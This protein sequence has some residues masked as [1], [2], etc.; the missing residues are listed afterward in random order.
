MVWDEADVCAC[1]CV[2]VRA[3]VSVCEWDDVDVDVHSR[4]RLWRRISSVLLSDWSRPTDCSAPA[5]LYKA[6]SS[7]SASPTHPD[8]ISH[9]IST[10]TH[11]H[12]SLNCT[13][14]EYH[15]TNWIVLKMKVNVPKTTPTVSRHKETL[16]QQQP[17]RFSVHKTH[18]LQGVKNKSTS[19]YTKHNQSNENMQRFEDIKV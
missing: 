4:K 14:T 16:P 17:K 3:C 1:V 12:Y 7:T 6:D 2:C 13:F 18:H 10:T 5:C 15:Q 19:F 8:S 11:T 9:C